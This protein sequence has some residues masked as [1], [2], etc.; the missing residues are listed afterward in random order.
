LIAAIFW[1]FFQTNFA[2]FSCEMCIA[3]AFSAEAIAVSDAIS[4]RIAFS[5][6]K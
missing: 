3:E 6:K 4:F 2:V 5:L 1:A